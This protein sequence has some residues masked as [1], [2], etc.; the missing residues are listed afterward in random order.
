MTKN[1][2]QL[3]LNYKRTAYTRKGYMGIVTLLANTI[4]GVSSLQVVK[5]CLDNSEEWQLYINGD[6]T[7]IR[8]KESLQI[9]GGN[10]YNDQNDSFENNVEEDEDDSV[11]YV[12]FILIIYL[13]NLLL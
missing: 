6:L 5:D 7:E 1:N 10:D 8:K 4:E 12:R 3:I 11:N 2:R 9:G 13:L